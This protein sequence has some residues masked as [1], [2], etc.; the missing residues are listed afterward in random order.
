MQVRALAVI[1]AGPR[2]LRKCGHEPRI[3]RPVHHGRFEGKAPP[4]VLLDPLN[5]VERLPMPGGQLFK[6]A[7]HGDQTETAVLSC[8]HQRRVDPHG[9]NGLAIDQVRRIQ[10]AINLAVRRKTLNKRSGKRAVFLVGRRGLMFTNVRSALVREHLIK[11]THIDWSSLSGCHGNC[12]WL[13]I[14]YEMEIGAGEHGTAQ[15]D[16]VDQHFPCVA[17]AAQVRLAGVVVDFV[18]RFK[19]SLFGPFVAERLKGRLYYF[20]GTGECHG[21]TSV[22]DTPS[23]A[24]A[25]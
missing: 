1:G 20:F 6:L 9:L 18:D 2:V 23:L 14:R 17:A 5:P 3:W 15:V 8:V 21:L 16:I 19:W 10:I 4:S 12:E 25:S 11:A 7:L 22:T 13:L 24:G